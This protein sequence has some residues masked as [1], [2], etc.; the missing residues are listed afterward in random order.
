VAKQSGSA[1]VVGSAPSSP[2][3]AVPT[4]AVQR[5]LDLPPRPSTPDNVSA[6]QAATPEPVLVVSTEK[7]LPSAVPVPDRIADPIRK[8]TVSVRNPLAALLSTLARRDVEIYRKYS[9]RV[10]AAASPT[11][12]RLKQRAAA[13]NPPDRPPSQFAQQLYRMGERPRALI[14]DGTE[15]LQQRLE[16]S[17]TAVVVF[18]AVLIVACVALAWL[19]LY[20]WN[21]Y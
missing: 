5:D 20:L 16:Q 19:G 13:L 8:P 10:R 18:T 7:T 4:E 15:R 3:D 9:A 14:T 6:Q 12:Q 1:R 2:Q 17:D 21:R 11:I